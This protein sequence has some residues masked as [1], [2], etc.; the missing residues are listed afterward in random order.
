MR[1]LRPETEVSQIFQVKWNVHEF[2]KNYSRVFCYHRRRYTYIQRFSTRTQ[3]DGPFIVVF[4]TRRVQTSLP[5]YVFTNAMGR[6][7]QAYPEICSN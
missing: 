6:I 5:R 2:M 7:G 1:I 3:Y 4:V